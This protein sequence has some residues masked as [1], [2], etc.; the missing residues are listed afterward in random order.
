MTKVNFVDVTRSSRGRLVLGVALAVGIAT[1]LLVP[2]MMSDDTARPLQVAKGIPLAQQTAE[3]AQAAQATLQAQA[4]TRAALSVHVVGNQLVNA[5]GQPVI[6]QGVDRD[7][8]DFNCVEGRGVFDG[9]TGPSSIAAMLS[10]HINAVR[11]PLNEQCWLGARGVPPQFGGSAYQDAIAAYVDALTASGIYAILD[12]HKNAPGDQIN[13]HTFMQMADADHSPT[14]WKQVATRFAANG[15]VLFDLFN[16]P[17]N[18]SWTCWRDG[19]TCDGVP[20]Q[21]AGMQTLVQ[22][23]R[24]TGASNVLLLSGM[25]WGSDL[26]QWLAYMPADPLHNLVASWHVYTADIGCATV[27]CFDQDAAPVVAQVPLIAAEFGTEVFGH[28]CGLSGVDTLLIWLDQHNAGYLAW[29]WNV[30]EQTCGSL[31]LIT[32]WDGTPKAPNGTYFRAHLLAAVHAISP[33]LK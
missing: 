19:G 29:S 28:V 14:F 32:A 8:T 26:S 15:M 17:H 27:A 7:G 23:V 10:W 18:I 3:A 20:F 1:R 31:S 33:T 11:I 9:P 6:L 12:L 21:V 22:A 5:V 25:Q 16:E 13:A 30:G 24:S 4:S 2:T